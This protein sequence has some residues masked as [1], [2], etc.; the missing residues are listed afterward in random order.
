M[1]DFQCEKTYFTMIC[2]PSNNIV[3]QVMFVDSPLFS[4][5]VTVKASRFTGVPWFLLLA[6]E[7][8]GFFI[9]DVIIS[10]II[11]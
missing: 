3:L 6:Y 1:R 10:D 8:G 9:R 11:M 2:T 7:T 5:C 4:G